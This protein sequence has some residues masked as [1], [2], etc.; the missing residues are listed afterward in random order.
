MNEDR[1]LIIKWL[2]S[3]D[4]EKWSRARHKTTGNQTDLMC[5]KEADQFEVKT[6]VWKCAMTTGLN[7]YPWESWESWE[8]SG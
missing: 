5:L 2:E 1:A 8:A 6:T 3:P 7:G 4:G